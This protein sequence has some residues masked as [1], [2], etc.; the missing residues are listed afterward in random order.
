[1]TL[2]I[3]ALIVGVVGYLV[4]PHISSILWEGGHKADERSFAFAMRWLF[5][6]IAVF[7]LTLGGWIGFGWFLLFGLAALVA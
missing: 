3:L 6:V 1:M 7:I 2:F 5:G 4:A